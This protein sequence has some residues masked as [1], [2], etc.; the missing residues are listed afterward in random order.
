M[1][2]G[3]CR[4]RARTQGASHLSLLLTLSVLVASDSASTLWTFIL[5][6]STMAVL[7][8]ISII[9]LVK[10]VTSIGYMALAQFNTVVVI[11]G[12][13][14]FIDKI[15]SPLTWVGIVVCLIASTAYV[16]VRRGGIS[17]TR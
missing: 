11:G 14:A 13:A 12:A 9:G 7:Y 15:T 6:G 5:L 4:S 1:R 3:S 8:N 2:Q 17:E 10:E 16:F